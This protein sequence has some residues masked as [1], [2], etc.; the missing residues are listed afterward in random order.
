MATGTIYLTMGEIACHLLLHADIYSD[1][2]KTYKV[3]NLFQIE[4][5]LNVMET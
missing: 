5:V 2:A 4:L 1:I 3:Y